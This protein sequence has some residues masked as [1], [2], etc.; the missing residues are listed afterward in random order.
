MRERK[1]ARECALFLLE[2]RDRTEQEM[3]GKL[4]EREYLPE[5]IDEVIHFLKEYRYIDDAEYAKRYIRV[6][7]ARKSSRQLR[8]ELERKGVDRELIALALEE[9]PV[10]EE[11]QLQLL[12]QKK[13]Y[14]PGQR[15]EP[16]AYRK[17]MAALARKGYSYE[18]IR[19][20]TG[21]NQEL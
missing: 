21:P 20:L 14:Q 8:G 2:Y 4:T 7:S 17:L 16:A 10:D 19:K 15:M 11:E 1:S 9:E 3:R 12:L 5:E 18:L 6:Y 13:G